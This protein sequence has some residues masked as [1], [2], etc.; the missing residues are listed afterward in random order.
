MQSKESRVLTN[1][2]LS[3]PYLTDFDFTIVI[4]VIENPCLVGFIKI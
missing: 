2:L 1:F 4:P 3:S